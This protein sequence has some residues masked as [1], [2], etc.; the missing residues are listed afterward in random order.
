[1]HDEHILKIFTLAFIHMNLN[2]GF[3]FWDF[4]V[5]SIIIDDINNF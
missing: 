4:Q 5:A 1:M 3:S 2:Y